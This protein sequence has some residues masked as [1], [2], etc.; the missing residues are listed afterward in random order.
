MGTCCCCIK[1][2]DEDSEWY[3]SRES[4]PPL[5]IKADIPYNSSLSDREIASL[6]RQEY[7]HQNK[8]KM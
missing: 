3:Y 2:K 6:Y 8:Y 5:D 7:M 1:C 4:L